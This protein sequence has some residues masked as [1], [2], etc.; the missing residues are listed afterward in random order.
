MATRTLNEGA[1]TMNAADWGGSSPVSGDTAIIA[2]G[3]A[4]VASPADYSAFA[5][6]LAFLYYRPEFSGV[7]GSAASPWKVDVDV[8]GVGV[9]SYCAGGGAVYRQAAG[10]NNLIDQLQVNSANGHYI[11]TGGTATVGYMHRGRLTV[12]ASAAITT[13]NVY[14]GVVIIEDGT[15]GTTVNQWGGT[16]ITKRGYTTI[17]SYGGDLSLDALGDTV[18]TL[19]QFSPLSRVLRL[20]G[21]ITTLNGYAGAYDASRLR[22]TAAATTVNVHGL[23]KGTTV[24]PAG[25]SLNATYNYFGAVTGDLGPS[26]P[27]GGGF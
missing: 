12:G 7:I 15:A 27:F 21:D 22:T 2:R 16:V 25:I 9:E 20:D 1:T 8:G 18:T 17:N 3:N 26:F 23:W 19:N 13:L 5:E 24:A 6:G 11:L 14:G 10:D 4:T